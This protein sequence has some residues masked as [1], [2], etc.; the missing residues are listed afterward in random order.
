MNT[1]L[2]VHSFV[3]Y[4]ALCMALSKKTTRNDLDV[5]DGSNLRSFRGFRFLLL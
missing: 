4:E 2:L 1:A 3:S 5:V